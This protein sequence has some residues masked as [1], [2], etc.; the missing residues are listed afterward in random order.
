MIALLGSSGFVRVSVFSKSVVGR[1]GLAFGSVDVPAS[2]TRLLAPIKQPKGKSSE[3]EPDH[4]T[5]V[6][7]KDGTGYGA[8]DAG[9]LV[10]ACRDP[11]RFRDLVGTERANVWVR[12]KLRAS[13]AS[14]RTQ[15]AIELIAAVGE[16]N[17]TGRRCRT[18]FNGRKRHHVM[19]S[20]CCAAAIRDPRGAPQT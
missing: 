6:P 18:G 17:P 16:L 10:V 20:K 1:T 9:S 14:N 8:P 2:G 5:K 19:D 4:P 3:D 15:V 7:L 13:H 12:E 11:L